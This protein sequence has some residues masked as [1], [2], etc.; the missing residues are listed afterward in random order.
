MGKEGEGTHVETVVTSL[1]DLG[2]SAD[3]TNLGLLFFLLFLGHVDET[4]FECDGEGDERV[5]GVVFVDP[6]FDL[7]E[8]R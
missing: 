8:P 4:F 7:G 1:G 3:S 2:Q 5:S 6:A